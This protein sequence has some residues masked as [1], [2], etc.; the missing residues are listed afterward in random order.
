MRSEIELI[1][2]LF[3]LNECSVRVERAEYGPVVRQ[4]VLDCW[5]RAPL[6]DQKE[7][8]GRDDCDPT[9]TKLRLTHC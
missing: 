1:D 8:P 9:K 2:R 3:P 4:E 6:V 7:G 5:Q